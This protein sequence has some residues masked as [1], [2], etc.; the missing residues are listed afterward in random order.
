M[1]KSSF[2]SKNRFSSNPVNLDMPRSTFDMPSNLVTAFRCGWLVPIYYEE[3]LPGD[4]FKMSL[5]QTAR[6]STLLFP[7]MDNAY[8]DTYFF[9]VPNRLVWDHWKEFCGEN[10]VSAWYNTEELQ[11]PQFAIPSGGFAL[12]SLADFLGMPVGTSPTNSTVKSVSALPGRA[13]RLIWNEWFRDENL[14]DPLL[15]NTGDV[16]SDST[17]YDL[18]QVNRYHDYFSS[19][20]PSPQKGPSVFL[21]LGLAPVIT[22]TDHI[23]QPAASDS[24]HFASN[25][26]FG[27]SLYHTF[28]AFSGPSDPY[29]LY[30]QVYNEG[31]DVTSG[32]AFVVPSNLWSDMSQNTNLTV[33]AMRQAFAIQRFYEKSARGGTRYAELVRSNFGVVS[34]DARVQRPEYLGGSH[35]MLNVQ[36]VAQTSPG[37]ADQTSLASLGAYS[38][39]SDNKGIFN[40]SF[41]EH[42]MI[43]GFCCVRTD[44]SYSSGLPKKYTRK[45]RFDYYWPSLANIGEMPIKNHEIAYMGAAT[46]DEIFGYQ[47]AY[48]DYR[49]HPN[50]V[51]GYI[52]P[53]VTGGLGAWTYADYYSTKPSLSGSWIREG[54]A[55]FKRALEVQ[56]TDAQ[57]IANFYFNVKATRPMPLYSI[58]GLLDHH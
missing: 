6:Q 38:L 34:P 39:T 50:A 20:L 46:D 52:R 4:S 43:I 5:S 19:A 14:Q 26:E 37:S 3:V 42:G 44:R 16:E 7:V 40:K 23:T 10:N 51:T 31:S 24:I 32:T 22:G 1:S 53:Q 17:L 13:C 11:I 28:A 12:N 35:V 8:L 18:L 56:D 45:T 2:D 33:N 55:H 41:T 25:Q 36:Q 9:F 54:N 58:P 21:P 48:A 47:E 27:D 49:Y 30:G 29:K 15:V 57:I